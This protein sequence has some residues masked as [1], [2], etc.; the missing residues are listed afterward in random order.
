MARELALT[1]QHSGST[2]TMSSL[3][4]VSVNSGV[5]QPVRN[6]SVYGA[7]KH[8]A[9]FSSNRQQDQPSAIPSRNEGL[10]QKKMTS[11]DENVCVNS[12]RETGAVNQK[13]A[14]IQV[15]SV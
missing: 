1:K 7:R 5:Q 4:E 3:G 8:L 12:I 6:N 13:F 2:N 15:Q 10:P 11:M 9:N 14:N